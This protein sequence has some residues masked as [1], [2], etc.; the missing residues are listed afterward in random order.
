MII[1]W[2]EK[3]EDMNAYYWSSKSGRVCWFNTEDL[4]SG[5]RDL[6]DF[7][8]PA[9]TSSYTVTKSQLLEHKSDKF[10]LWVAHLSAPSLSGWYRLD[11]SFLKDPDG[12]IYNRT[13]G[14]FEECQSLH[15]HIPPGV[16]VDELN[17]RPKVTQLPIDH[18]IRDSTEQPDQIPNLSPQQ[19]KAWIDSLGEQLDKAKVNSLSK[20]LDK[21]LEVIRK[22]P[23]AVAEFSEAL[24]KMTE[25][26]Q[27]ADRHEKVEPDETEVV[28][29]EPTDG[30]WS[31]P[32]VNEPP[33]PIHSAIPGYDEVRAAGLL[34]PTE[35]SADK[36]GAMI[37]S[38]SRLLAYVGEHK[39]DWEADWSDFNQPKWMVY[40]LYGGHWTAMG[41]ATELPVLGTVY[42]PEHVAKELA[43]RLN[44]G[45]VEF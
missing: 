45:E 23:A 14:P 8:N 10:N 29:W 5:F 27:T 44:K 16:F 30:R 32:A 35:E 36:A 26:C 11:G 24:R 15:I 6:E 33:A 3:P 4:R 17:S 39:G 43:D 13:F 20:E 22:V 1:D 18:L 21:A 12:R 40:Q 9:D 31:C 41:A 34:R 7:L 25:A 42:M 19:L 28:K 37:R 2:N 38:Y